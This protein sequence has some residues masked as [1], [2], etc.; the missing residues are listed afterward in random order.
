MEEEN[1]YNCHFQIGDEILDIKSEKMVKPDEAEKIK[2]TV[3]TSE[4]DDSNTVIRVFEIEDSDSI[5]LFIG[6]H[7]GRF[8]DIQ[9]Y[10]ASQLTGTLSYYRR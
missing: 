5:K 9:N 4:G 10:Q 1:S 6:E 3:F 2:V 8:F 7:V